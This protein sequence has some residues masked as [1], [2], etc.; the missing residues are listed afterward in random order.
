M[1][2][3]EERYA[4]GTLFEGMVSLRALLSVMARDAA[5]PDATVAP[6]EGIS[7]PVL[8]HGTLAEENSDWQSKTASLPEG[9][10]LKT[11]CPPER[12][13]SL[14]PNL[15]AGRK[16][17]RV[18]YDRDNARKKAAEY[19]FLLHRGEEFGFPVELHAREE[20]DG[21]AVGSSHGGVIALC[22]ERILPPL[23]SSA[24]PARG[25][26]V[27]L[28]GIEDPYNFGYALRSLYA[29]G[30]DGVLLGQRNWMS[31]AGVVCRASAGASELLPLY[32]SEEASCL[33]LF[34]ARG[35]R[36]VCADREKAVSLFDA[37]LSLP[38]FLVIGGEKRGI[39]RTL[40]ETADLRV[41][42]DYGRDFG[43]SLSAAS[44]AAVAGFEVLRQ[45]RK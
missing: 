5:R 8:E 19:R 2:K 40:L 10:P 45:N 32:L 12:T 22:S 15:P 28:D 25:F 16:I 23:S 26:Y 27:L 6:A 4:P 11:D 41:K 39:S 13:A 30:V 7:S 18:L 38:L 17:L 37:D 34:R 1:K 35:Y 9:L 31:A 20:I 14:P 43:A 24:L 29:A 33:S 44:A 42:I 3:E 36:L 21:M